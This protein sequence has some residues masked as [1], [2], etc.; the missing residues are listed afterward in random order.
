MDQDT[1][2]APAPAPG[3]DPGIAGLESLFA[4]LEARL[5][6][7]V[8]ARLDALETRRQ[9]AERTVLAE[10]FAL[11]H[12]DFQE[13]ADSGALAAQQRDN[14]LL[15]AVGAYYAH[16]LAETRRL[17]AAERERLRAEALAEGEARAMDR[18]RTRRGSLALGAAPAA[19][20]R[21]QGDD[22]RLTAPEQFGGT[23]AVLA[24]RLSARR[25]DAGL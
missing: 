23:N 5:D 16:H 8:E 4:D 15:D 14:P 6:A 13:L 22:P 1:T 10:R 17:E 18:L 21:G 9:E 12:P 24:A 2:F 11:E 7:L 25:R 3:A 20:L 19:P